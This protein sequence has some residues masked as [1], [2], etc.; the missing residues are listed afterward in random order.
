M[1]NLILTLPQET[2]DR[3]KIEAARAGMDIEDWATRRLGLS[4]EAAPF[5]RAD[6]DASEALRR[7]ARYDETGEFVDGDEAL[8]AFVAEVEAR[9]ATR[10]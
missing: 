7:L 3:L 6:D 1:A 10:R 9:A 2:I 5:T 8:N 4:E